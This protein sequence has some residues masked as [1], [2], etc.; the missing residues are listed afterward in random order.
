MN[1]IIAEV[2]PIDITALTEQAQIWLELVG[3]E[4]LNHHYQRM[5]FEIARVM[6][7]DSIDAHYKALALEETFEQ[8]D[9]IDQVIMLEYIDKYYHFNNKRW[10]K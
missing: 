7:D 8:Y 3:F 1:I 9:E 4:F 2:V 10:T 6:S 5:M